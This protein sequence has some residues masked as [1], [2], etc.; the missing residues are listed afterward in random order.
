MSLQDKHF[1]KIHKIFHHLNDQVNLKKT[2]LPLNLV[3]HY[4]NFHKDH[5]LKDVCQA[6][7][8]DKIYSQ[9]DNG[10]LSNNNN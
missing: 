7:Q 8:N 1:H 6:K 4:M 9:K 3:N 2:K 10:I 5:L